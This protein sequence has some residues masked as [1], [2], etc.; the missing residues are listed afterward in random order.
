M[1]TCALAHHAHRAPPH[2]ARMRTPAPPR[3]HAH[4]AVFQ[5]GIIQSFN[6]DAASAMLFYAIAVLG[7]LRRA[8]RS[9]FFLPISVIGSIARGTQRLTCSMRAPWH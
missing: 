7:G 9:R 2:H 6:P 4:P 1:R 8:M 3:A 5:M